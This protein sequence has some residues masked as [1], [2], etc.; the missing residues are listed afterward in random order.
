MEKI[1]AMFGSIR[2]YAALAL[3]MVIYFETTGMMDTATANALKAFLVTA[4]TVRT[5]DSVAT[6][7]G[8]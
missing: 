7:I 4:I 6:K 8:A 3:G 2:F 1:K 5:A